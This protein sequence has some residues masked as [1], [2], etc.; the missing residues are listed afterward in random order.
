VSDAPETHQRIGVPEVVVDAAAS[1]AE[2]LASDFLAEGNRAVARHNFFSV[3]LPGGSIA[4][5]FFP[6]L[7]RVPFDWS[8]T[9]LFWADERAVPPRDPES[10][11]GQACSLW[12]AP[13][14]VPAERIHRMPA[15]DPD[16][17]QAAATY[18]AELQR[19]A[20]TSPRLDL[21]LLGVGPDG[22][23]ASLFPGHPVLEDARNL[24]AVVHNAPK[25]PG[26]RMTLTMRVLAAGER[27]VVVALGT[28]K[29]AAIREVLA[30]PESELPVARVV[31]RAAR[32]LILLD[33]DAAS[34]IDE[35]AFRK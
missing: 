19:I 28:T 6:R 9:E 25:P 20:G 3:A 30:R 10:N 5:N 16:I 18:A 23:V 4:T 15:N 21:V 34:L 24:V 2:R 11:Y 1:L 35:N 32:A 14:K 22:H 12:L 26:R 13:A 27:V 31:R 7:A 29:A 17:A 33:P 8:R